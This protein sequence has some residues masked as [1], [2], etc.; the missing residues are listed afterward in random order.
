MGVKEIGFG[1]VDWIH[2]AKYRG[3]W[4]P[5]AK[6]IMNLRGSIKFGNFFAI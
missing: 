1:T 5:V 2:L 6:S 4:R 3:Q